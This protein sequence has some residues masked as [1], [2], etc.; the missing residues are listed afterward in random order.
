MPWVFF[1]PCVL[2]LLGSVSV[3]VISVHFECT[4]CP[5]CG[6]RWHR[7]SNRLTGLGQLVIALEVKR[8][9][10]YNL[11]TETEL[12]SGNTARFIMLAFWFFRSKT[13]EDCPPRP[14]V[15]SHCLWG[16][17]T[18]A[19]ASRPAA[20]GQVQDPGA[21]QAGWEGEAGRASEV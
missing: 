3:L 14:S 20:R 7:P 6:K 10:V 13:V 12:G 16:G 18:E 1:L 5:T 21:T 19:L 11:Q 2:A 9:F 15:C 4:S 8:G 17:V